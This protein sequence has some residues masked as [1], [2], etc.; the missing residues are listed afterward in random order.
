VDNYL[1]IDKNLAFYD[2]YQIFLAGK[3]VLKTTLNAKIENLTFKTDVNLK[4]GL[5]F[6]DANKKL[7]TPFNFNFY[8]FKDL[9]SSST[10]N[11]DLKV[12]PSSYTGKWIDLQTGENSHNSLGIS[13]NNPELKLKFNDETKFY[14]DFDEEF[15]VKY[16]KSASKSAK[17]AKNGV[18]IERFLQNSENQMTPQNQQNVEKVPI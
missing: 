7:S 6:Y 12:L 5:H 8:V 10:L 2:S 18:K 13:G 17:K 4:I 16:T 3:N 15:D 14:S 11:N 9:I 1:Q